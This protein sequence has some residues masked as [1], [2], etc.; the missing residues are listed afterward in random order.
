MEI[1]FYS[2]D[3]VRESVMSEELGGI[4]PGVLFR[5]AGCNEIEAAADRTCRKYAETKERT[6]R[7]DSGG[8]N[9]IERPL[10]GT[11]RRERL[12]EALLLRVLTNNVGISLRN[13]QFLGEAS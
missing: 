4:D 10:S 11:E 5:G 7:S 2:D 9:S 6:E 13:A 12:S 3:T 8:T 1:L